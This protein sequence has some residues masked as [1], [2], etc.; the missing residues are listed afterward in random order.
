ML[1]FDAHLDLSMNAME[2]N[3]DL[4]RPLEEIRARERGK[5][6]KPDRGNGTVSF[7]EMRRGHVGLCVATQI[8][9]FVRPTNPLP[10][11]FSQEQA[12]AQ[13][14]GQLAWY[15][16]ME[17][18]SQLVSIRTRGDLEKQFSM[19]QSPSETAPIGYIL[20]LEGADSI[21]SMRH[22]ERAYAD[23]LRAL[24]PAHYGL[25]L[26][27]QGTDAT[28]GLSRRGRELIAEMDRLG[29]ILDATHLCDDSFWEAIKLFKGPIW[30]SHQNCRELI[31]H[32]RQ[33]SDEQIKVL[34][35]RGAVFGSVFDAWMMFP[36]WIRGKNTPAG[37][38][39]KIENIIDHMDHICQLAGNANH[40]GI[41]S[42]LDGAFG[43]E[44]T[45]QDLNS[46]AD[47]ARIP[48]LL[49]KRGYNEEATKSAM[50]G[51]FIRFLRTAL[52]T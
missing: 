48:D 11:W 21:V 15:R 51:N 10:G 45:P 33:F 19:W 37:S 44:Q 46:I 24:G 2:W 26:Y 39:L 18:A 35:E 49:R 1:I 28:G 9:R 31:P 29:M 4:T 30:A 47:L 52:P 16:A 8:A 5:S 25:G 40:I 36:N 17:D 13:T 41:G 43:T 6:D 12:W 3:R 42:D 27:A 14:Q 34:I 22:L 20:S 32:N 50:H 38:N 23:G 7:P